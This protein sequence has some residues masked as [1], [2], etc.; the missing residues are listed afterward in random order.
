MEN[1][2]VK[3]Q[4]KTIFSIFDK[5]CRKPRRKLVFPTGFRHVS[6]IRLYD[7]FSTLPISDDSSIVTEFMNI[8]LHISLK[9]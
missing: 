1:N 5:C 2:L 3:A 9:V 6:K 4:K 8:P 7:T